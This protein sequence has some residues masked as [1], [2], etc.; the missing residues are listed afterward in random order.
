MRPLE[1]VIYLTSTFDYCRR[2]LSL[3]G[4]GGCTSNAVGNRGRLIRPTTSDDIDSIS[5]PAVI[6]I[7]PQKKLLETSIKNSS[8]IVGILIDG[9]SSNDTNDS[10]SE[11]EI[12]PQ[13]LNNSCSILRN[14]NGIDFR[15]IHIQKPIFLLT[16]Q[17]FIRKL[18]E[19]SSDTNKQHVEV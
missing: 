4:V 9:S 13:S 15:R 14:E 3:N 12:C 10:F 18:I 1:S 16:N 11:V 8:N 19:L 6:L 17:S 7:K 5:F 2:Y